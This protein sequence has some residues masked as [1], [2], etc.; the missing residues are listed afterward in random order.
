M[1]CVLV[2]VV[3]WG[4]LLLGGRLAKDRQ[5]WPLYRIGGRLLQCFLSIA[6]VVGTPGCI[7]RLSW[8]AGRGCLVLLLWLDQVLVDVVGIV[9]RG[10]VSRTLYRAY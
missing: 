7:T 5:V 9:F 6:L 1:S 2:R 8:H 4:R 3:T 10:S